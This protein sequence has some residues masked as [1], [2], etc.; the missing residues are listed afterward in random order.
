MADPQ[1][2]PASVR[3]LDSAALT[4]VSTL[5]RPRLLISMALMLLAWSAIT[6]QAARWLLLPPVDWRTALALTGAGFIG[7]GWSVYILIGFRNAMIYVGTS[8]LYG[9][10]APP[11]ERE[12]FML[13][14]FAL[15]A[16]HHQLNGDTDPI[17]AATDDVNAYRTRRLR[18][19]EL[20]RAW[21]EATQDLLRRQ[22]GC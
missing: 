1:P 5:S 15:R 18:P 8:S 16:R 12:R 3:R 2:E 13:A 20:G 21:T 14:L 9:C 17:G 10:P 19:P 4:D 11:G 22:P 6:W 7:G